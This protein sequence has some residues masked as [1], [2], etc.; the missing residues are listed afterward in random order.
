MRK[1]VFFGL[2]LMALSVGAVAQKLTW[3]PDV[4][5]SAV[6]F[7]VTHMLI[8]DVPGRFKDFNATLEQKSND[9]FAGSTLEATITAASVDTDNE[10]RD[11]HLRG[12][13]FFNVEKFPMLK[14]KSTSFE[15]T[16]NNTYKVKGDL[17]IRDV[18]KPVVL[19][20]VFTGR[21]QDPWGNT[22]AGF[23]ATTSIN[24]FDFGVKWN[25]TLDTGGLVVGE[26][27]D[28]SLAM[29]MVLQKVS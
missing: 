11:A 23:R 20:V 8:M 1:L 6:K 22:R 25:T 17:T 10:K 4:S 9:D 19:D 18:T 3:K 26:K 28:I 21:V 12:D 15:K 2:A 14:F 16:G 29:E 24:R 27:V 13:D 7:S 5:H